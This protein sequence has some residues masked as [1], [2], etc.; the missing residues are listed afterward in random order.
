M[1]AP[2]RVLVRTA[3]SLVSAGTERAVLEGTSKSS[4]LSAAGDPGT[5]AKALDVLRREGP[6]G[7]ID[8]VKARAVP[9]VSITFARPWI[10]LTPTR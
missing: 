6:A 9:P 2:G 8:R 10:T 7:I 5:I 1:A 3:F 4:L